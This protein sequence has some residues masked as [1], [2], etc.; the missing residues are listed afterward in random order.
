MDSSVD[1]LLNLGH[2][3]THNWSWALDSHKDVTYC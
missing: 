2:L 1:A 3:Y